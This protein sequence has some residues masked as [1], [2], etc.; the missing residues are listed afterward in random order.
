MYVAVLYLPDDKDNGLVYKI[1]RN[2]DPL[3]G[4][5][6]TYGW[7]TAAVRIGHVDKRFKVCCTLR[8]FLMRDNAS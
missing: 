8:N 5:T 3:I 2:S 4:R 6:L 1:W 7:R